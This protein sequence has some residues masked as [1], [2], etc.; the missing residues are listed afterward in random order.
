MKRKER[1]QSL[2]LER[3]LRKNKMIDSARLANVIFDH[4]KKIQHTEYSMICEEIES[5]KLTMNSYVIDYKRKDMI[6]GN[7]FFSLNDGTRILLKE[8][9]LNTITSL[10]LDKNALIGYMSESMENV[11]NVLRE[12]ING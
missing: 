10:D 11:Q 8:E 6:N 4:G 7:I 3:R 9:T 12:I 2:S 1:L 5:D